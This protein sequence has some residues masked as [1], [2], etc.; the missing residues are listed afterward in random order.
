MEGWSESI[1]PTQLFY[2]KKKKRNFLSEGNYQAVSLSS[3]LPSISQNTYFLGTSSF[4]CDLKE[5]KKSNSGWNTRLFACL[6]SVERCHG[7]WEPGSALFTEE[8]M[9]FHRQWAG[10]CFVIK[11]GKNLFFFPTKQRKDVH[12]VKWSMRSSESS[13]TG[14]CAARTG[15]VFFCRLKIRLDALKRKTIIAHRRSLSQCGAPRHLM[16]FV[17]FK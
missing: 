6:M 7:G 15:M 2:L 17:L 5:K 8:H 4:P 12:S 13:V 14:K 9:V 1:Y 10:R 16:Y 11:C 3:I